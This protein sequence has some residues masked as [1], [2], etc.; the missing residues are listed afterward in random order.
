MRWVVWSV[1]IA[2]ALIVLAMMI[3]LPTPM[4]G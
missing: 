4:K 3:T 2:L 1:V